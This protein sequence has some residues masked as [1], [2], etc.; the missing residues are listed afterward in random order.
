[1][2]LFYW[3]LKPRVSNLTAYRFYLLWTLGSVIF[4][5]I[6]PEKKSRYLL[7]VLAPLAMTTAFYV[8]YVIKN[9]RTNFTKR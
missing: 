6:I 8:E 7:P 4:L 1:M 5:S 3:Y 9:F 2:G